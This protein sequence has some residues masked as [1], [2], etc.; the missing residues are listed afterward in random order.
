MI[1]QLGYL[2][3]C[4]NWIRPYDLVIFDWDKSLIAAAFKV[5]N[6]DNT[7]FIILEA[8]DTYKIYNDKFHIKCVN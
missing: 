6:K 8:I 3:S 2:N 7:K 5:N 4:H 1:K